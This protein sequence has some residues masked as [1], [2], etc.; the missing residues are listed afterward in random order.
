MVQLQCCVAAHPSTRPTSCFTQTH[1][2]DKLLWRSLN[3]EYNKAAG[4]TTLTERH[5]W[6]SS[7]NWPLPVLAALQR[8]LVY[9]QHWCNHSRPWGLPPEACPKGD[10]KHTTGVIHRDQHSFSMQTCN[11]HVH[12]T[13][14][15]LV[16]HYKN[17]VWGEG[18]Q[19]RK[20]VSS[21]YEICFQCLRIDIGRKMH[22]KK[23]KYE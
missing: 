5:E 16:S 8:C 23:R 1:H 2:T 6:K 13:V 7:L 11:R 17:P 12:L 14:P 22:I 21:V 18:C 4:T 15:T 3:K 9:W 20:Q 10:K 19:Q